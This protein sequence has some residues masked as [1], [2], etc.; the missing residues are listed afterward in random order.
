ME[1]ITLQWTMGESLVSTVRAPGNIYTE[2]FHQPEL[3]VVPWGNNDQQGFQV[4]LFPNPVHS[5]LTVNVRS[6][7]DNEV[8]VEV[9]DLMGRKLY[10]RGYLKPNFQHDINLKELPSSVYLIRFIEDETG[11][12]KV[13]KVHKTR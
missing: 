5:I 2:G 6:D 9:L 12:T 13:F 8:N 10:D 1:G 11:I 4:N 3:I 7:S